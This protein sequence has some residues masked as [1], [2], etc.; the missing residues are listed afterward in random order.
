MTSQTTSLLSSLFIFSINEFKYKY[1]WSS[2]LVIYLRNSAVTTGGPGGLGPPKL[3]S[4]IVV[5]LEITS[6]LLQKINTTCN[7]QK[8]TFN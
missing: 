3:F 4:K 5:K 8:D 2:F 6:Y 7:K 1:V